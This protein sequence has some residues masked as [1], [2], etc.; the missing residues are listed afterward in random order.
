MSSESGEQEVYSKA[1]VDQMFRELLEVNSHLLG[2]FMGLK[3]HDG[4]ITEED[5]IYR[6]RQV[7]E[8]AQGASSKIIFGTLADQLE[9]GQA[10][11]FKVID[12]GNDVT[13]VSHPAITRVLW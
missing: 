4:T 6:L 1:A 11:T 13:P 5:A 12:G 2:L 9:A 8:L 10:P 7:V 3:V